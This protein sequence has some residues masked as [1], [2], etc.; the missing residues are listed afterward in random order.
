MSDYTF[1]SPL[2]HA[3]KIFT[4]TCQI[5]WAKPVDKVYNLIRGLSPYPAAFTFLDGKKL[6]I[7]KA[8]K[9][10][11]T[12]TTAP[13]KFESDKKN[14]LRFACADGYI[15]IKELQLEGKKKMTVADFLRGYRW[16]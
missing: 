9:T 5:D 4:A 15:S 1:E 7:F 11:D 16:L 2:K 13:G 6:K 12:T 3:P 14:F 10:Q 8:E